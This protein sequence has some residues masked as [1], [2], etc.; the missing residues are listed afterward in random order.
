MV[1]AIGAALHDAMAADDRVVVFGEDVARQGGVFRVTEGLQA[2]LGPERCFDT[3]LAES[4][5]IGASIGMA[6]R[7]F[8]PVPEIQFDGFTL[9]RVR[10]DRQPP[11]QVPLALPGARCQCR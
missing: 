2:T 11:R 8:R 5:I 7:G 1:E 4:A 3:P 10:A 9:P 6:I